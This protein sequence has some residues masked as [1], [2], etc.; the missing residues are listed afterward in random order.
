[1]ETPRELDL[2]LDHLVRTTR[3][4]RGEASRVVADVLAFYAE[5]PERFVARRHAELRAE[6]RSNPEIF[7]Q[8]A[9]ELGERRF[10]AP[11]VSERQIRRW[12]YG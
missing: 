6:R 9:R 8:I 7:A 11:A 4:E 5:P 2:L 3:L 10:A 12:I 1:M